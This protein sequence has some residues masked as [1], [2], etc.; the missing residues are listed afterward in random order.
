MMTKRIIVLL[1]LSL[2]VFAWGQLPDAANYTNQLIIKFKGNE[3]GHPRGVLPNAQIMAVL[4]EKAG[5]RLEHFRAMSMGADVFRLPSRT[6]LNDAQL[7]SQKLNEL[8]IV[9]YAEPDARKYPAVT[10]TAA[11]FTN[12][13]VDG[14][15]IQ[16]YDNATANNGAS[17]S[18]TVSSISAE[19]AWAD[20][21][22]TPGGTNVSTIAILDTGI[23]PHQE[24]D[25]LAW[26]GGLY[27]PSGRF[28]SGYDFISNNLIANDVDDD[29]SADGND[30]DSDPTDVGDF[31]TTAESGTDGVF[32]DCPVVDSS[33]HGTAVTSIAAAS[34]AA[35]NIAG[36]SWGS[37]ILPV[38]VL[39][40]C[41][42]ATS[43][44]AD[45]IVWASGGSVSGVAANANPADIIN[46]SLG[47]TGSCSNT[48]QTAI[49]T[50][51]SNGSVIVVAAGNETSENSSA[52]ANCS[53]VIS[54]AALSNGGRLA[55]YSN[56]GSTVDISAPG[57]D[58]T[59]QTT[60][61]VTSADEA[62]CLFYATN[63]GLDAPDTADTT[64]YITGQ[65]TSFAAP[66]VSGVI[67]LM[68]DVNNTLTES[69]IRSIL[70]NGSNVNSFP[71]FPAE[72]DTN[73]CDTSICG[74]GMLD[75][76]LAID[77]AAATVG[78]SSSSESSD[79]PSAG[80]GGGGSVFPG[81]MLLLGAVGLLRIRR[82]L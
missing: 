18:F 72:N 68:L 1:L 48:E 19:A 40:K 53:N 79:D 49:N 44:I 61:A 76:K 82:K 47:G 23:T 11:W 24:F 14:G 54:V 57:G 64:S 8:S 42:G 45:A 39:G 52:P 65:G 10:A 71:T 43:D 56:F 5:V 31:V 28:L 59:C 36:V 29:G 41:G 17:L 74:S 20:F 38:R 51:R 66:L 4:R 6:H 67:A 3:Q 80:S 25:S 33:W 27:S 73:A 62:T 15:Q 32:L 46:M 70:S 63:A 34:G 55:S 78:G 69:D 2:P 37:N 9:D 81:L 35:Q 16:L 21:G 12:N 50:A 75:A 30:R 13:G 58:G 7:I 60:G 22:S 26:A 77:A